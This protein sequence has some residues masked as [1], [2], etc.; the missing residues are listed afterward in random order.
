VHAFQRVADRHREQRRAAAGGLRE[1]PADVL[2]PQ[3]RP[4][5]IVHGDPFDVSRQRREPRAHRVLPLGPAG[6]R[7]GE[8]LGARKIARER[9]PADEV[10][11]RKHRHDHFDLRTGRER[12]DRAH[13]QRA[14]TQR[15]EGLRKGGAEPFAATRGQDQSRDAHGG[16]R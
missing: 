10:R 3:Q 13:H 9:G 7:L 15:Q 6:H 2:G 12:L 16:A 5:G 8:L 4:R 1:H 11:G 14:A